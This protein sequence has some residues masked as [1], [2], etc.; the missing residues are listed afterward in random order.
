MASLMFSAANKSSAVVFNYLV[1]TRY[2]Q[3]AT[4]LP[5]KLKGLDAA[6]KYTVKE[7]NLY[8][9]TTSV[10]APNA[11]YSGDFLMTVGINPQVNG[12]RTSVLLMVDEVK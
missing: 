10:I 4:P 3:T 7:I 12:R 6:K 11:I 8:P 9:G 5:I 2:R 1:D